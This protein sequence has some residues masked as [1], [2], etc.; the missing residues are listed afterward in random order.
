MS[1]LSDFFQ[2]HFVAFGAVT[3]FLWMQGGTQYRKKD[4]FSAVSWLVIGVVIAL[5]GVVWGAMAKQW[6]GLLASACVLVYGVGQI[7]PIIAE[8]K[9]N[10]LAAMS[11]SE[12]VRQ[13]FAKEHGGGLILPDGWFGRP[14]DN[15]HQ[16]T[17]IKHED[18]TLTL[19]LDSRLM[20]MFE[21]LRGVKFQG[22]D[23]VLSEFTK[24]HC[25]FHSYD[26]AGSQHK[27]Q[28]SDGEVK[29]VSLR[30]N[31]H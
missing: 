19:V 10:A 28:Y 6:L 11:A 24:L 15:Q 27:T 4:K 30:L 7:R 2:Q 18:N 22:H 14:Y 12:T 23:L 9:H 16:L 17:L 1:S 3:A 25:E 21:G 26:D 29:F 20:L 8:G 31:T 5:I 13:W